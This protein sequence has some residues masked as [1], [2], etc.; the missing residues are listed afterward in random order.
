MGFEVERDDDTQ[1]RFIVKEPRLNDN[2][3]D[4]SSNLRKN[5]RPLWHCLQRG[6]RDIEILTPFSYQ[7][8]QDAMTVIQISNKLFDESTEKKEEDDWQEEHVTQMSTDISATEE[9]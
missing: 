3:Q 8:L 2:F 1:N 7:A 9:D 4:K 6:P 5:K